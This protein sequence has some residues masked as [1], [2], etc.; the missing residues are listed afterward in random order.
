MNAATT[1]DDKTLTASSY[2]WDLDND[3]QYDDATGTTATT[4]FL[5]AGAK[6]IGLRV[7]DSDGVAAA[8]THNVTVLANATPVAR[9]TFTPARPN[10]GAT[11]TF[12]ASTSTDDDPL[13]AN[14]YS[15]DFNGDGVFTDAT[16]VSPTTS[17][18]TSGAKSVTLRVTDADGAAG[19]VTV[20]VPVNRAPSAAFS[21]N[22]QTPRVGETVTFTSAASDD[23]ALPTT[24]GT[25]SWDLDNDGQFDDGSAATATRAYTSAGR[26]DGADARPG[27]GRP[28]DHRDRGPSRS[29]SSSPRPRSP[30]PRPIPLPGQTVTFR[31]TS[32]PSPGRSDHGPGVGFRRN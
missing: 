12:N 14:A 1:T 6:T 4:S 11:V 23:V 27:R 22:P 5:T 29:S 9:A 19:P 8:I 24:A 30:R 2:A 15:W 10:P 20:S 7:T 26:P 25:I 18:A 32:T 28:R 31:S 3:G 16:G 13:P 17:F 21:F